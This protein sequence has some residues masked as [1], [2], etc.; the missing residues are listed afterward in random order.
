MCQVTIVQQFTRREQPLWQRCAAVCLTS[1]VLDSDALSSLLPWP[2]LRQLRAL[3]PEALGL[4]RGQRWDVALAEFEHC[5][6]PD[7]Q[8]CSLAELQW[9]AEQHDDALATYLR[10]LDLR[11][12]ALCIQCEPCPKKV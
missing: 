2:L 7:F 4:G 11:G 3:E 8:Q 1:K 12:A 10:S 5:L 9:E 6:E